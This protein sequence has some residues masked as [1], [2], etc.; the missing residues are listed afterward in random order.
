MRFIALLCLFCSIASATQLGGIAAGGMSLE[1]IVNEQ[2]VA[3]IDSI[4]PNPA[5]S[6]ITVHFGGHGT[7]D[8]SIA[9][10]SWSS[11]VEG[12][13]IGTSAYFTKSNLHIGEHTIWFK[14]QDNLGVW[15]DSVSDNLS[16]TEP[17][18]PTIGAE[19]WN[20]DDSKDG[21]PIGGGAGYTDT[22]I[23]KTSAGNYV[24]VTNYAGLISA[25]DG[26]DEGDTIYI[27]DTCH[28]RIQNIATD[29]YIHNG[30]IIAS[31]RGKPSGDTVLPGALLYV[32]ASDFG[33]AWDDPK[34]MLFTAHSPAHSCRITGIRFRGEY[35]E[36]E[37]D[38]DTTKY[39]GSPTTYMGGITLSQDNGEVDNCEFWGFGKNP[40]AVNGSNC[41]VHNNYLHHGA[42]YYYAYGM[43]HNND[44]E[45]IW[46]A[47]IM[48][49]RGEH[50]LNSATD[51]SPYGHWVTCYNYYLQNTPGS[52]R[53]GADYAPADTGYNN[54][55]MCPAD[56]FVCHHR[57]SGESVD[58][59]YFHHNWLYNGVTAYGWPGNTK[60]KVE[61]DHNGLTWPTDADN[62]KPTA[63]ISLDKHS[64]SSLPCTSYVT[65]T[66]SSDPNGSLLEFWYEFG[67]SSEPTNYQHKYAYD[68]T[69]KH[70]YDGIGKYTI[71]LLVKD[72]DGMID[73]TRDS[74]II[75]ATSDSCLVF[76]VAD[77]SCESEDGMV[78]QCY[79][80]K[81]T[82][83]LHWKCWERDLYL[84]HGWE[85][86]EID[87]SDSLAEWETDSITVKFRCYCNTTDS[88]DNPAAFFDDVYMTCGNVLNG[89]FEE[90]DDARCG[91]PPVAD[92]DN[93]TGSQ[94]TP[95]SADLYA[96]R[97]NI[98]AHTGH[99]CLQVGR[100]QFTGGSWASGDYAQSYQR[101]GLD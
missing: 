5:D 88:Y 99:G 28:I 82:G 3:S 70:I 97:P 24:L 23:R 12:E 20:S 21:Y 81:T 54:T 63:V 58:T 14:V 37:G 27:D 94:Y 4:T 30:C 86:V 72:D 8:G 65:A 38:Q 64:A 85:R 71:E 59:A 40:I 61:N 16:I 7:D 101:V 100:A 48:N 76:W 56:N 74:L 50:C 39:A 69:A 84:N 29:A 42:R 75:E 67:D 73:I 66:G 92:A 77:R 87:L 26:V 41:Y 57:T 83:D 32:D 22:I 36:L 90:P 93:W 11:D 17:T 13:Q 45:C 91:T 34:A 60:H 44:A 46:E 52:E 98:Y 18:P 78:A 51:E 68:D 62:V 10:W 47:N 9:A 2:P 6:G 33:T 31:G 79:I 43:Q 80:E 1:A 49:P 96:I 89:G 95:S 25:L 15:S 35:S 19:A 55:C 53:H